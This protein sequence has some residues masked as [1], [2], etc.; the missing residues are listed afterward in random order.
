MPD[1]S[2]IDLMRWAAELMTSLGFSRGHGFYAL[3]WLHDQWCPLH[4]DHAPDVWS[5]CQ[6]APDGVLVVHVGTPSECRIPVVE[7]GIPI[8]PVRTRTGASTGRR[9]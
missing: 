7:N 1:R 8:L 9:D 4:P 6:C 3:L 2:R 5:R